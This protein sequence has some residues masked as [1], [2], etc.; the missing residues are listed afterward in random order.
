MR[1]LLFLL[2]AGF[3]LSGCA[4][5]QP[6]PVIQYKTIVIAPEDSLLLDCDMEP[7]PV[8]EDYLKLPEWTLKEGILIDMSQKQM[9]NITKCNIRLK[10]LRAW[11]AEQ[12]KLYR[13]K[14]I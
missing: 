1:T 6:E 10:N 14:K 11:K 9:V 8:I 3:I 5:T 7:P 2:F 13:D 12:L 4:T